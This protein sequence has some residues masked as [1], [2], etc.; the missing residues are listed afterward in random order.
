MIGEDESRWH[1][2]AETAAHFGVGKA[3]VYANCKAR[4]WPHH[5]TGTHAKAAIRFSPEDWRMIDELLKVPAITPVI[6]VGPS[7]AQI[8]RGLRRLNRTQPVRNS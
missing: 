3:T 6:P 4:T 2:V 5:R 7:M 1:T 8:Q